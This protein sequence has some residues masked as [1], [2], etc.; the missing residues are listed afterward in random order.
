[1]IADHISA[2]LDW[3]PVQ[4]GKVVRAFLRAAA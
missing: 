3:Y 1:M 4:G 2:S